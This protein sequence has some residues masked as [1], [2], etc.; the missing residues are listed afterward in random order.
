MP[1]SCSRFTPLLAVGSLSSKVACGS[2]DAEEHE[3]YGEVVDAQ[4][5]GR[6]PSYAMKLLAVALDHVNDAPGG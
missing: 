3:S 5:G 2:L 1:A 4:R 6:S